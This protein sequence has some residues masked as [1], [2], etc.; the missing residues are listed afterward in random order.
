M[1]FKSA[2]KM[3]A[4]LIPYLKNAKWREI[5]TESTVTSPEYVR[6]RILLH[7]Q[8][9]QEQGQICVSVCMGDIA[10]GKSLCV[11]N[12]PHCEAEISFFSGI[13]FFLFVSTFQLTAL[14]LKR[15]YLRLHCYTLRHTCCVQN[16]YVFIYTCICICKYIRIYMFIY[17]YMYMYNI[18]TCIH[19]Y[20]CIYTCI[21]IYVNTYVHTYILKLNNGC[22]C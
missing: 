13:T 16:L 2:I 15:L 11:S 6:F 22:A 4:S 14:V 19:I 20:I 18:K 10:W 17:T 9:V 7:I 12:I 1:Q 3:M 21:Y 8:L 5:S